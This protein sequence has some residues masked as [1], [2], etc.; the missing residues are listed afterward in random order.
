MTSVSC[1]SPEHLVGVYGGQPEAVGVAEV[2]AGSPAVAL[3]EGSTAELLQAGAGGGQ[4]LAGALCS[5]TGVLGGGGGDGEGEEEEEEEEDGKEEGEEEEEKSRGEE[6]R[7]RKRGGTRK[8]R[9]R[10]WGERKKRGL[11]KKPFG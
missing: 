5:C 6:R 8:R 7:W 1:L 11:K 3:D 4:R 2:V 10:G 9:R